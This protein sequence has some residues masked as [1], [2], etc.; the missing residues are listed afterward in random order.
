MSYLF[1]RTNVLTIAFQEGIHTMFP[2]TMLENAY[3]IYS[4]RSNG[5]WTWK[6][7]EG[8]VLENIALLVIGQ[9]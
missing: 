1:L 2:S 9:V 4:A 3:A 7:R 8:N 5:E 6:R